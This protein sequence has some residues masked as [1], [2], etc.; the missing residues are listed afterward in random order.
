[1]SKVFLAMQKVINRLRNKD[2]T[3]DCEALFCI[4]VLFNH[5]DISQ[6]E[7][8]ILVKLGGQVVLHFDKCGPNKIAVMKA[9]RAFAP[10]VH[11][12]GMGLQEAKDLV[13][14]RA[15]L[16]MSYEEGELI[17][18]HCEEVGATVSLTKLENA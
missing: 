14:A 17:Q 4:G 10:I 18:V 13:E 5:C 6:E 15:S 7:V 12:E 3:F 11:G 9:L 8:M 1:V 16:T 2:G